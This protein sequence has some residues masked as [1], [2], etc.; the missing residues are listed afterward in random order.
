M[1]YVVKWLTLW[2]VAPALAGSIPVASAIGNKLLQLACK[3]I[4]EFVILVIRAVR[5]AVYPADF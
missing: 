5:K 2:F 3:R 1:A 4:A